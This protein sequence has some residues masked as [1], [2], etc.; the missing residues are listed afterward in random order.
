MAGFA[1][2]FTAEVEAMAELHGWKNPV[3]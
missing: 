2:D 3:T 1:R